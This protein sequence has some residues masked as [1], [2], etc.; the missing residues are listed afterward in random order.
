MTKKQ[1]L[2][3]CIVTAVVFAGIAAA[4]TY[5]AIDLR[6]QDDINIAGEKYQRLL[7]FFEIDHVSEMVGQ[8]YY[9]E[10]ETDQLVEGALEGVME[11]LGDGYSRFYDER[12]FQYFDENTE[13]SYMAQGMLV[14]KDAET[15]YIVVERVFPDT[16]AYEQNIVAGNYITAIDGMDTLSMDAEC[17]VS[18][19]RGKNGVE[20]SLDI[21][22][23]ETPISLTFTRKSTDTQVVFTDMLGDNV[24]Y[25]DIVEFSGS[26][27]N[28]FKKAIDTME[29]E[30]AKAIVLDIRNT[31]GGYISQ[32]SAVA[33]LL[34][35]EGN[36]Y[37]TKGR[38]NAVFTVSAKEGV[39][40]ALPMVLLVNGETKGVAE[41]FA[42][43]LQDNGAAQVVGEQTFGKGVVMSTLRVPNSGDG[44]R[45]VTA[46]YY[47]PKGNA[48]NEKGVTPDEIVAMTAN[49]ETSDQDPQLQKAIELANSIA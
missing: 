40:T 1:I 41:V 4:A 3:L 29:K 6:H 36:I 23:G 30:G 27:V 20:I 45:M 22:A 25:I 33:D 16:P 37:S 8:S 9:A 35:E 14:D 21:L 26:S 48:I 32:A 43:A 24:G 38:D 31:P 19:L 5:F 44:V 47:S 15:G 49:A 13:G 39:E 10:V 2:L 12:Y 42:A 11:N 17:A 34:L 28:D 46:F 18:C 7:E